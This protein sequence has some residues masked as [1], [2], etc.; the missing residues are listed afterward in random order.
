MTG[1]DARSMV[2]AYWLD[3]S[4]EAIASADAEF[5]AG[6]YSFAVNRAYYACFYALSAVLL[7]DGQK[8]GKHSGVRAALHRQ[9]RMVFWNR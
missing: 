7:S 9:R 3:K 6:R 1:D 4:A 2:L 8:Y 5:A